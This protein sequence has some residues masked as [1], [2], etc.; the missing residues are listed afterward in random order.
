MIA[1]DPRQAARDAVAANPT[2]AATAL[3]F[4]SIDARLIVFRLAPGQ[5]VAPHRSPST[6]M[7]T[8][9]QG[10]GILSG[11]DGERRCRA[12]EVVIYAPGELHGMR[13]DAEEL[14]LLATI[15]PRPGERQANDVTVRGAGEGI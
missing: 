9:L 10:E 13:A 11:G 3:I 6:V 12:G 8:V 4:D 1:I 2:R 15:S 14:Q 7:L 5:A